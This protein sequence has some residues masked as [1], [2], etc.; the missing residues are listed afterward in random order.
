MK[1]LMLCCIIVFFS[2]KG[3]TQPAP[4]TAD[5]IPVV[6]GKVL[7]TVNFQ[8]DLSKAEMHKRAYS[9]LVGD[10]KP[11]SGTFG[12]DTGD[13][14]ICRI[15]DYLSIVNGVFQSYGVFMTYTVALTY[16]NGACNMVVKDI[17]YMEKSAFLAKQSA[18]RGTTLPEWSAMDIMIDHKF[19]LLLIG[20][21]SERITGA[22]LVR[23]NGIVKDLH[24]S[25]V[26]K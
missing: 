14:T 7:F 21:V 23:I 9:Y 24:A 8:P 17:S 5:S 3:F 18:R 26:E 4:F 16:R 1:K 22:S 11:Y 25:F 6:D 19:R 10:L 15:T 13:H 2:C 12:R 20:K